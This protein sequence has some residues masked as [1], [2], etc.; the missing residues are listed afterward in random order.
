[1]LALF[2]ALAAL[3]SVYGLFTDPAW[4]AAQLSL[5]Q[6]IFP[7]STIGIIEEQVTRLSATSSDALSFGFSWDSVS[8]SGAPM[9]E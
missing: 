3:V 9:P 7:E 6:G 4:I 8:R 5:L 1:L 2:P